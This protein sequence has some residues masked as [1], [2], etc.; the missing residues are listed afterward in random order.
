MTAWW[1]AYFMATKK[2]KDALV[3]AYRRPRP[4]T[5][6]DEPLTI[7]MNVNL[8]V[9]GALTLSMVPAPLP[10]PPLKAVFTL[11]YEGFAVKGDAP[12]AYTLPADK[13]IT[14]AVA[15]Q[16]AQGNDVDLPQGNVQ[17]ETSNQTILTSTP[18]ANDDQQCS[19]IPAGPLGNAQVTCTGRN[20][21]GTSVIAT[22]DVSIVSGD[23]VTGTIQPQ[24][25][26]QPIPN[27]TPPNPP[28]DTAPHPE[29][30]AQSRRR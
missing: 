23:A 1:G 25:E 21:D 3:S 11:W 24:G 9:G 5:P 26:P 20:N 29:P 15:Y 30:H 18:D 17:W 4:P 14:V 28:Q 16:D 13:M 22:L 8:N 12:M 10:P 19:L 7:N 2:K 6:P 27:P